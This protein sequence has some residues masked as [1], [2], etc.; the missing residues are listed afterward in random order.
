M[1]SLRFEWDDRKNTANKRR[2]KVSF[3]EAV[4]VFSDGNALLIADPD[5]SDD[6][7]RFLLLGFSLLLRL[8]I[9]VHCYREDESII[10]I[11]SARKANKLERSQY[12]KRLKQ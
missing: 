12:D 6:E 4:T 7:D 8:L 2:N 10:R 11:V 3:E 1:S 9:V 5:H